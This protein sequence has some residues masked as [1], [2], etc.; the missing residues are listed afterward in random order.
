MKA[1]CLSL[2]LIIIIVFGYGSINILSYQTFTNP[3]IEQVKVQSWSTPSN[4]SQL[5]LSQCICFKHELSV[6]FSGPI[7]Q[8]GKKFLKNFSSRRDGPVKST[9]TSSGG[10]RIFKRGFP[11]SNNIKHTHLGLAPPI[12]YLGLRKFA[13]SCNLKFYWWSHQHW[14]VYVL[15]TDQW[16]SIRCHSIISHLIVEFD[17]SDLFIS[18]R[19]GGFGN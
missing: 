15:N 7:L 6:L 5:A 17:K 2:G 4:V 19:R 8:V 16:I 10:S 3:S 1:S 9:E 18:Q 11:K 14:D 12:I 13:H